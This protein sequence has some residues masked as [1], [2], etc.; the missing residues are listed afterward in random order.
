MSDST[1]NQI[2]TLQFGSA[3]ISDQFPAV[4][5]DLPYLESLILENLTNLTGYIPSTLAKL[6][7]LSF[8]ISEVEFP[9]NM[10]SLDLNTNLITGTLPAS[11]ASLQYLYHLNVSHNGLCSQIPTGGRLQRLDSSAYLPNRCF[12]GAPLPACKRF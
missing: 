8:D 3:N 4:V 9:A 1:T 6:N 5:S 7:H 12:C 2:S 10:T 11:L